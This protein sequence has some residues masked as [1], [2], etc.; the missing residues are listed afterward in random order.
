M[1]KQ[2][3]TLEIDNVPED[4]ELTGEYR[5]PKRT[6][7]PESIEPFMDCI[8][9]KWVFC[10]HFSTHETKQ[11]I[12]R[13]IKKVREMYEDEKI[14]L[15]ANTP[16][17]IVYIKGFGWNIPTGT[18]NTWETWAIIDKNGTAG[19]PHKFEKEV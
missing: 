3:V 9:G 18:P 12:L 8:D 6:H 2:T 16:G 13:K 17:I 7:N 5:V 4:H 15:V 10:K 11:W 14:G 19:S 1:K